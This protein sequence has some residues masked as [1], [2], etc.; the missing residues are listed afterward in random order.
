MKKTLLTER[1]QELAGIKPLYISEREGAASNL[2]LKSLARQ[3]FQRF[4]NLGADVELTN[5]RMVINKAKTGDRDEKNVWIYYQDDKI[6]VTLVGEKAI[7]FEEKIKKLGAKFK[8]PPTGFRDGETWGGQKTRN[9]VI[10]PGETTS[11]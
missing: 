9:I 5:D 11:E 6:E 3:L 7:E 8:F 2:E 10:K 1:F 4:K